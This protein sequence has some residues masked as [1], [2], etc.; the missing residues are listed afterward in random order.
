MNT[1]LKSVIGGRKCLRK[2]VMEGPNTHNGIREA[3][4][5]EMTFIPSPEGVVQVW[6]G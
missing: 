2:F 5:D 4:P 3:L 1:Q 6:K